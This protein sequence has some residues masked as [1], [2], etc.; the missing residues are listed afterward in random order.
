MSAND[1]RSSAWSTICS[2]ICCGIMLPST[3]A[4]RASPSTILHWHSRSYKA[5]N[6]GFRWEAKAFFLKITVAKLD[7]RTWRAAAYCSSNG[8][9]WEYMNNNTLRSILPMRAIVHLFVPWQR[10]L[11]LP[12]RYLIFAHCDDASLQLF[13]VTTQYYS[14][15]TTMVCQTSA[16]YL[17]RLQRN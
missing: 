10:E 9:C 11:I 16:A 6:W 17:F 7:G 14:K 4:F 15:I 5:L 13:L 12:R 8:T 2:H 3:S 1:V